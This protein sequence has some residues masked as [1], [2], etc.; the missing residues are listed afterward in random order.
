MRSLGL[1]HVIKCTI[2]KCARIPSVCYIQGERVCAYKK[3]QL[4]CESSFIHLRTGKEVLTFQT[5]SS[6]NNRYLQSYLA[7]ST[8]VER[9]VYKFLVLNATSLYSHLVNMN[10]LSQCAIVIILFLTCTK[11]S[12]F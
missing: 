4:S 10:T 6:N 9:K 3:P 2:V 11:V 12:L 8:S 7:N 1:Y 5:R